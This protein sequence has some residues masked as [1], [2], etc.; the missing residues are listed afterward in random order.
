MYLFKKLQSMIIDRERHLSLH[1]EPL[2]LFPPPD[3]KCGIPSPRVLFFV[4]PPLA[5]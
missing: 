1:R 5:R 2:R 4:G 3:P